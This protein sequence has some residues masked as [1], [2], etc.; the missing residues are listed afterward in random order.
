MEE[1]VLTQDPN[2]YRLFCL[3]TNRGNLTLFAPDRTILSSVR[4]KD[5]LFLA[6]KDE[7]IFDVIGKSIVEEPLQI[8]CSDE[9]GVE[10]YQW[11]YKLKSNSNQEYKPIR[12]ANKKSYMP[13]LEDVGCILQ[14]TAHRKTATE[15]TQMVAITRKPV[16][17]G[18]NI[19]VEYQLTV[20][21]VEAELN[22]EYSAYCVIVAEDDIFKTKVIKSMKPRWNHEVQAILHDWPPQSKLKVKVWNSNYLGKDSAI[23][24]TQVDLSGLLR[25]GVVEYKGDL[26][27]FK[28]KTGKINL[29]LQCNASKSYVGLPPN[30]V[31]SKAQQKKGTIAG[32]LANLGFKKLQGIS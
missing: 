28:F 3:Q 20:N 17:I 12:N 21:V 24:E 29:R 4:D 25:E 8:I 1:T 9:L 26:V 32:M 19:V 7:I 6:P 10:N 30:H 2:N 15:D 22:D 23:G 18:N 5:Q 11:H 14:C 13:V 27:L 31:H 16:T